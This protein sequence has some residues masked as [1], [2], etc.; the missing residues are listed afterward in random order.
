MDFKANN[1]NFKKITGLT[2]SSM[3]K[4]LLRRLNSGEHYLLKKDLEMH[5]ID[6]KLIADFFQSIKGRAIIEMAIIVSPNC[7]SLN[8]LF[9]NVPKEVLIKT[10]IFD[11]LAI[12]KKFLKVEARGEAK[13]RTND[14]KQIENFKLLLCIGVSNVEQFMSVNNEEEWITNNIKKNYEIALTQYKEFN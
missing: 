2:F 14:V 13:G 8:F 1:T 12:F 10:L 6:E 9:K 7:D 11:N 5:G 4:Q 3:S